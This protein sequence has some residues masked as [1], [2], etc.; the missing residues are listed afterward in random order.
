MLGLAKYLH[1]YRCNKDKPPE[2]GVEMRPGKWVC[3]KCWTLVR[4]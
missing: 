2:G 3:A 1:C 4:L